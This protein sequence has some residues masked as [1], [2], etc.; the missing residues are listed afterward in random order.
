MMLTTF[1]N[2]QDKWF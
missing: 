2:H 1:Q